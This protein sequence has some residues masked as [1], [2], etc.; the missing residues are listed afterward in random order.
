MTSAEYLESIKTRL[1]IDPIVV[2]FQI[3]RERAT[4]A[5]G[6]L[7][8]KLTLLDDSQLEFAEYFT[9]SAD[10]QVA[11]VTYNYHWATAHS[12]LIQRWD[13]TPHHPDLP[14]FPYHAHVANSAEP[15]PAQPLSIF[16]VLDEVASRLK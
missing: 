4:S 15:I 10:G 8:A 7:R 14:N 13:N 12:E 5:D 9:V 2:S 1:L 6:Y 11:V 3:V 16:A